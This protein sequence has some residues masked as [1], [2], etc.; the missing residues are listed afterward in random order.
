MYP[1][2]GL[3]P[4]LPYQRRRVKHSIQMYK[5]YRVRKLATPLARHMR[6][7]IATL[8]EPFAPP[9]TVAYVPLHQK[10]RLTRGFNQ[11][12]LLGAH[13]ADH[14]QVPLDERLYRAVSTAPQMSLSATTRASNMR[15]VFQSSP[16][17][18]SL[19]EP[20]LLVDDVATTLAT[21]RACA[22]V[23]KAEG[24]TAVYGFPL[25]A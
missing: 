23:L 19:R 20:V 11:A 25:A 14:Y 12:H 21:L 4:V 17:H 13:L 15:G 7:R 2:D 22:S 3:I 6:D 8:P 24:A 5:Y 9:K 1:L 18:P 10:R 16:G